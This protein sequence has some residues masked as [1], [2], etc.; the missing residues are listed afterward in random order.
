MKD[1]KYYE[2]KFKDYP[3]VVDIVGFRQM[4]GGIGDGTAR[5]LLREKRV[6]HFLVYKNNHDAYCIPK[7]WAID[8]I[9][10]DHYQ[11]YKTKLKVQV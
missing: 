5:K 9:I 8:Y 10:S 6:R 3:D 1:R 11:N 4:L 7:C 2:T